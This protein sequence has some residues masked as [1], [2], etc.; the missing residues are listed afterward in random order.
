MS[1]VRSYI[2]FGGGGTKTHWPLLLWLTMV[3]DVILQVEIQV[4]RK[5]EEWSSPSVCEEG[6]LGG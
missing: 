4:V 2:G 1:D 3:S 5:S 6:E